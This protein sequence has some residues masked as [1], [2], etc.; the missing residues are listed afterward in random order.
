[1][2][3]PF[4]LYGLTVSLW[5]RKIVCSLLPRSLPPLVCVCVCVRLG[6]LVNRQMLDIMDHS[7][8]SKPPHF[9]SLF[10]FF[11][12]FVCCWKRLPLV[13]TTD[14]VPGRSGFSRGQTEVETFFYYYEAFCLSATLCVPEKSRLWNRSHGT[15]P[16]TEDICFRCV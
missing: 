11:P 10:I 13:P 2:L 6:G 3:I 4:I 16:R 9:N 15:S 1:M 8:V 12:W 7:L 14:V 5:A